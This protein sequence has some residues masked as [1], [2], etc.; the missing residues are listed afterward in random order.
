VLKITGAAGARKAKSGYF[1]IPAG[2]ASCHRRGMPAVTDDGWLNFANTVYMKWVLAIPSKRISQCTGSYSVLLCMEGTFL[3]SGGITMN[4]QP[5]KNILIVLAVLLP[6]PFLSGC[7]ARSGGGAVV[8]PM[9][10]EPA[11]VDSVMAI[12]VHEDRPNGITNVFFS[13][14]EQIYLWIYWINVEGR[15]K[16]EVRWFSPDEEVDDPPY[17]EETQSFT[18]T[19][20]QQITWFFIDKPSGGFTKGDWSVEIFLNDNFERTHIFTVE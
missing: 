16:V 6:I 7:E 19:T 10:D 14:D 11:I 15:N 12:D 8:T 2:F 4:Y 20:G 9:R 18:S 5:W 3:S 1:L 13:D 17:W